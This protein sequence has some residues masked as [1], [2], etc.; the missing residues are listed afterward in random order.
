MFQFPRSAP[1]AYSIQPAV[2][3]HDPRQVFPLGDLG[4]LAWLQLARAY[5]SYPT[6][7][8]ASWRQSIHHAPFV[9]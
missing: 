3:G 9:A 2:T 8:F 7:V 5:R 1:R 6:S 4:V